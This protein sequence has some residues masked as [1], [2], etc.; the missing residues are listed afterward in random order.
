MRLGWYDFVFDLPDDWEITRYATAAPSGR[1]EFMNRHGTL[2]RISWEGCKKLPDEER[3]LTEY[4]SRYLLQFDKDEFQGFSGIQTERIGPFLL[5]YRNPGE[6]CQAVAHLPDCKKM[7]MWVFPD[8]SPER[9]KTVWRPILESFVA[10]DAAWREWAAFGIQCKLP[11]GFELES[12]ACK[13]ADVWFAFQHKNMH[14]I[15]VHRWGLPRELL[16]SWDLDAYFRHVLRG[17]GVRVTHSAATTWRG[18]A[19]VE[20]SMETRGTRGMD[21]LHGGHWLGKG[22]I[23]HNTEEKRL[24]AWIQAAPKKVA[25]FEEAE[26]FPE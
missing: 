24:Y 3:I 8:Y 25:L 22:R 16:R 19:S 11:A 23:W 5:G 12:A 21:R 4:H 15:D 10:N 1:V 26:M 20:I 13:P 14:R 7:L 6:P 2:G 9:L 17:A 18:M